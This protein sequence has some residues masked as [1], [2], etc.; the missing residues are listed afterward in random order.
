MTRV[1]LATL[2][3]TYRVDELVR[4]RI[5]SVPTGMEVVELTSCNAL[6]KFRRA[7]MSQTSTRDRSTHPPSQAMRLALHRG[8]SRRDCSVAE[9]WSVRRSGK[10]V[11]PDLPG[12]R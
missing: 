10:V 6:N 7:A 12:V 2:P 8:G 11:L 4:V 3:H 9:R 5:E 1:R